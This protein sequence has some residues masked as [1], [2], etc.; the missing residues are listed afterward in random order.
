MDLWYQTA[1]ATRMTQIERHL[2]DI[3]EDTAEKALS[4]EYDGNPLTT[5]DSVGNPYTVAIQTESDGARE[6]VASCGTLEQIL[7]ITLPQR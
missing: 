4:G 2:D 6:V 3:A 5:L 1:T 7:Y